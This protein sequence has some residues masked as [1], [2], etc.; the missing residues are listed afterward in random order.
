[1]N[2]LKHWFALYTKSRHEF[3][4]EEHFNKTGIINYL[5]S[6]TKIKQWSDRKKKI[7]EPVLRGYIFIYATETE[8][9]EALEHYSVTRC[10]HDLG[11]P[12]VIPDWQ[13]ENL[14][15]MLQYKSDYFIKEGLVS[16]TMVE[17][18]EGPFSGVI[19]V[20]YSGSEG[21]SIAVSIE[22]LNRSVIAYLPK[23]SI[24]KVVE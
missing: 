18:I 12:A 9:L 14:K 21:K 7:K 2:E 22:L 4:A 13:I 5:P 20:V 15:R 23:E 8:R 10:V 11:R 16:G 3:K 17:I 19:G 6:V 1:M 24:E